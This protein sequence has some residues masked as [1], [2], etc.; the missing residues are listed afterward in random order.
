MNLDQIMMLIQDSLIG[1]KIPSGIKILTLKIKTFQNVVQF[2]NQA[3]IWNP[4]G[5]GHVLKTIWGAA[6]AP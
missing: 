1:V 4:H 3:D 2:Q 5:T 6:G